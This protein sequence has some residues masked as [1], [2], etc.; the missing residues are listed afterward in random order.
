M[1]DARGNFIIIERSKY[2]SDN[3]ILIIYWLDFLA[4]FRALQSAYVYYKRGKKLVHALT[5]GLLI[6]TTIFMCYNTISLHA[7]HIEIFCQINSWFVIISLSTSNAIVITI[8]GLRAYYAL[9]RKRIVAVGFTIYVI[10][11]VLLLMWR[12]I[13][14]RNI[15]LV[16][17]YCHA[18]PKV[19]YEITN[20]S[21][22]I[23]GYTIFSIIF[24]YVLWKAKRRFASHTYTLLM[25][26]FSSYASA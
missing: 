21:V 2:I 17:G 24:I 20:A 5:L 16:R 10:C 26:P 3:V 13:R 19:F 22:N 7:T 15:R 14:H 6:W 1:E 23:T 9:N 4:V 11:N 8:L 18:A 25:V 12:M